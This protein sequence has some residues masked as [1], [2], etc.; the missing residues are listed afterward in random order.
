M[1]F[2]HL[3]N[4][5]DYSILDGAIT[6]DN[7]IKRTVEL[8]MPAVALTDHGNMFG[9]IDFINLSKIFGS[10]ES[11]LNSFSS[12]FDILISVKVDM[13]YSKTQNH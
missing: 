11:F 9:A 6:V 7:L 1:D 4:H 5:S 12:F 2:V 3:H 10:L 13:C 8:G